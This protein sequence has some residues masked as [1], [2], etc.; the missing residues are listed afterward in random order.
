MK[1]IA[2]TL[3]FVGTVYLG[4]IGYQTIGPRQRLDDLPEST[5]NRH[6]QQ[7]KRAVRGHEQT[8]LAALTAQEATRVIKAFLLIGAGFLLQ[9]LGAITELLAI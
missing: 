5:G 4:W 7:W 9:M 1:A 8:K 3:G 2:A 6:W